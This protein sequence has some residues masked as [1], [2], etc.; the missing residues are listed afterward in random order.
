MTDE[1]DISD[2]LGVKV[3]HLPNGTIKLLQPHLIQQILDDL[4]FNKRMGTK[5]TPASSSVK[6]HRDLHGEPFYESWK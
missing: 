4:G 1:G 3:D 2:Y 5:N 6:L